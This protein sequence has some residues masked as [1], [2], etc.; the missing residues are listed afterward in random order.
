VEDELNEMYHVNF[1]LRRRERERE[2]I[3]ENEEGG[4]ADSFA[5]T[6]RAALLFSLGATVGALV[7]ATGMLSLLL[8]PGTPSNVFK[9]GA[10][11]LS[12]LTDFIGAGG[13]TAPLPILREAAL[14]IRGAIAGAAVDATEIV[15]DLL[16]PGTSMNVAFCCSLVGAARGAAFLVGT[17]TP[18]RSAAA[19]VVRGTMS[20]EA[21][22][23][24]SGLALKVPLPLLVMLV[25]LDWLLPF[26]EGLVAVEAA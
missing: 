26:A 8:W 11:G 16:C 1:T 4:G 14:V 6:R 25:L 5:A 2:N 10:A 21:C 13:G 24:G 9:L 18:A 3:R 7:D 17:A 22:V 15:P 20:G 23:A 19:R 12:D